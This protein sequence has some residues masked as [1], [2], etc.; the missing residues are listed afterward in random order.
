MPPKTRARL[1]SLTNGIVS[2]TSTTINYS[3]KTLWV[4]ATSILLLGIPYALALGEEQ[5]IMEEQRQAGMMA[6]GA[7]GMIQ[8]AGQG[9]QQEQGAKP[10][11]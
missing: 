5:Q 9:Q 10:A 3:G 8:S 11:L 6:E 7:Q 2:A 4:V 1:A